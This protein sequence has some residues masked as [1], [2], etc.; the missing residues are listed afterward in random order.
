MEG[1]S[2]GFTWLDHK[3]GDNQVTK[4]MVEWIL[5]TTSERREQG[6]KNRNMVNVAMNGLELPSN[7]LFIPF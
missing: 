4:T 6:E 2:Y 1:G 3:N 7:D 5:C